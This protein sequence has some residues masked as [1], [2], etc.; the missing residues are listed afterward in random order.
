M[1]TETYLK[2][3][4]SKAY[5]KYNVSG[6]SIPLSSVQSKLLEQEKQKNQ[7]TLVFAFIFELLGAAS[8]FVILFVALWAGAVLQ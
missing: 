1:N 7:I 4:P 3:E 6:D 8:L 2:S 5:N